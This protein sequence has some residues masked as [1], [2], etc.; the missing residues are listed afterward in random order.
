MIAVE[1]F[2]MDEKLRLVLVSEQVPLGEGRMMV[3]RQ[4]PGR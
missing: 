3:R 4:L 2:W 1:A